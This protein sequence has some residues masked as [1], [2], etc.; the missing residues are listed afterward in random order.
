MQGTTDFLIFLQE[1]RVSSPPFS[2]TGKGV[3]EVRGGD[4]RWLP[5]RPECGCQ[6]VIMSRMSMGGFKVFPLTPFLVVLPVPSP[7]NAA[8][9]FLDAPSLIELNGTDV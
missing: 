4:H 1:T 6:C 7:P 5:V 9:F 2:F 3:K 8:S